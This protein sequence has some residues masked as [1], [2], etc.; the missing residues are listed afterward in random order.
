M[1]GLGRKHPLFDRIRKSNIRPMIALLEKGRGRQH[2]DVLALLIGTLI[3]DLASHMVKQGP[4]KNHGK[5]VNADVFTFEV[6]AYAAHLLRSAYFAAHDEDYASDD[7]LD[8][9]AKGIGMVVGSVDKTCG[10]QTRAVMIARISE[11][12]E[13]DSTGMNL[14]STLMT[15][16]DANVPMTQYLR[17][18]DFRLDAVLASRVAALTGIAPTYADTLQRAIDEYALDDSRAS[19]TFALFARWSD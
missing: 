2:D 18:L 4:P 3:E 5:T 9:F 1:F 6:E 10:W 12:G 14:I 13:R 7:L 15:I 8:A 19:T 17:P 11:Y 16:G